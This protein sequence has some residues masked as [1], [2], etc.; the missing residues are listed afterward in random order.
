[1]FWA[2]VINKNKTWKSYSNSWFQYSLCIAIITIVIRHKTNPIFFWVMLIWTVTVILLQPEWCKD[3]RGKIFQE[4][5]Y[6][7]L[8]SSIQLGQKSFQ[9]LYLRSDRNVKNTDFIENR[10]LLFFTNLVKLYNERNEWIATLEKRAML[11]GR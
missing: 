10:P 9:G 4:K 8:D 6:F 2:H 3:T 7:L 1:M 11:T 5:F